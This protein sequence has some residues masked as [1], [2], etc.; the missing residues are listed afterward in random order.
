MTIGYRFAIGRYAV[1]FAEYDHFCEETNHEKPAD[2]GWGRGRQPVINV[3]WRE[4][5]AYV[6]GFRRTRGTLSVA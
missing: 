1:T 4:A 3:I 5:R 2:E 6:E